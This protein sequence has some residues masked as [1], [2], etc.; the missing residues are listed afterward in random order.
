MSGDAAVDRIAAGIK[1]VLYGSKLGSICFCPLARTKD[2]HIAARHVAGLRCEDLL[3]ATDLSQ[4]LLDLCEGKN[5]AVPR[6]SDRV[7]AAVSA[8]VAEAMLGSNV[9]GKPDAAI[10]LC[11]KA[12]S[13]DPRCAEAYGT[14]AALLDIT[15]GTAV[16]NGQRLGSVALRDKCTRL[17]IED[18][19]GRPLVAPP[20]A[21]SV[22]ASLPMATAAPAT[23]PEVADYVKSVG[24]YRL[25][26]LPQPHALLAA[27]VLRDAT[28]GWLEA[29]RRC[30]AAPD[31]TGLPPSAALQQAA[32]GL[33]LPSGDDCVAAAPA[34]EVAIVSSRGK[35]FKALLSIANEQ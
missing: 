15:G 11:V 21:G 6:C 34:R 33:L 14:L 29:T 5:T 28:L 23:C 30:V 7:I 35:A 22:A 19:A 13:M 16:A 31:S 10:A 2:S 32:D 27:V 9:G 26:K 4:Q 12:L 3:C 17:R 8:T 20:L 24:P 25:D 1:G 18:M